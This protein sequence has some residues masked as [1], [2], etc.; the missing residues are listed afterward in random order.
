N[1]LRLVNRP[2][3]TR[4]M[5]GVGAVGEKPVATRL[6]FY[7]LEIAAGGFAESEVDDYSKKWIDINK[8]YLHRSIDKTM[9]I[10][11]VHGH[12]MEPLIPDGSYCLFKYGVAGSR[13]SRVVLVKKS[14]YE[15]PDTQTSFTIKRYFSQKVAGSEFEWAHEKIE[16][17]P[18]N[19]D[20]PVLTVEPDEAEDFTI[21]AEFIQ[22][23]E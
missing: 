15:D 9:F 22:C 21:I 18:E 11:Q 14:G 19:P 6:P 17:R 23:I 20:Y 16:L 12:S 2:L 1:S 10:S 5:G 7:P 3:R 13:N 4:M 8:I